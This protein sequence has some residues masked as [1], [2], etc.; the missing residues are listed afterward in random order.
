MFDKVS[1]HATLPAR[2]LARA[3]RFYEEKLGLTPMYVEPDA[4]VVWYECGGTLFMLYA[5]E[6]AGTN[7]ATAATLHAADFDNICEGLRA[8]GIALED[9]E[10]SEEFKTVDGVM[11]MPDGNRC[12]W[13][14]DTEGNTL[15]LVAHVRAPVPA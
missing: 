14:K 6:F 1:M 3:R 5:S 12:V 4:Q 15:A 10:W 2:D 11:T 9:I 13:I 7:Q 8:R